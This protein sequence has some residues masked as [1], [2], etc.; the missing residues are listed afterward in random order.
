MS[1]FFIVFSAISVLA[2]A[3]CSS[4]ANVAAPP[5]DSTTDNA[6]ARKGDSAGDSADAG[7]CAGQ[8][9]DALCDD[10]NPCT[11]NDVC[12]ADGKCV[13][14]PLECSDN[15]TCTA[16][17]C[18]PKSQA[19][20]VHSPVENGADGKPLPCN[21]SNECTSKDECKTSGTCA[22][23]PITCDDNNS[24]TIDSCNEKTGCAH[25][26]TPNA[27]CSDGDPC[28]INDH[29]D[30]GI[31]LSG[32]KLECNDQNVCT[33]DSCDQLSGTC[34]YLP[35][36]EGQ[37]CNDG[38]ACTQGD[39]C[40]GGACKSGPNKPCVDGDPCTNDSCNS[41]TGACEYKFAAF[42][43]QP[44]DDGNKCTKNETC[45]ETAGKCVSTAVVDCNDGN[46]CTIDTCDKN[47]GCVY[48]SADGIAC[49]D[50]N[51]CTVGDTCSQKACKPGKLSCNDS[52]PCTIDTCNVQG[53]CV[54]K[55]SVGLGCDDGNACTNDDKC[56]ASA[57]CAGN[58][59]SCDDKN[60]CTS[61]TCDAVTGCKNSLTSGACDDGNTCTEG[62]LCKQGVC[63]PGKDKCDDGNACTVDSC[64]NETA[65]CI[66][67]PQPFASTC[68]VKGNICAA[69]I[70]ICGSDG[71]CV[72]SAK[73]DDKNA[74]TTDSCDANTGKCTNIVLA[75]GATC[76]TGTCVKGV[77]K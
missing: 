6:A 18:D 24:C 65:K 46:P 25:K 19:L 10:E 7:P 23:T 14:K 1:R 67:T 43:G 35:L 31:C 71:S 27:T 2:M 75:D 22:G 64:N 60:A 12:S 3:A 77:C 48:S 53:S 16:D 4:D 59:S 15:N 63:S 13:G 49:D 20:C 51:S 41:A 40:K 52:N 42:N 70:G 33:A 44:C 26:F 34:T 66:H 17:K 62:D 29:C 50:A 58:L 54:F 72:A 69:A 28:T 68:S 45:I 8:P 5:P 11:Q 36:P 32:S 47:A 39:A 37:G 74:C 56:D 38:D 21:D 30:N 73:C 57:S 9:A 76:D 61:D 55:P